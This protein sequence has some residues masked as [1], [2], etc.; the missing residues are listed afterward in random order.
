MFYGTQDEEYPEEWII[1][2]D[3]QPT[4]TKFERE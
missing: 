1:D 4:C 2:V 3:G